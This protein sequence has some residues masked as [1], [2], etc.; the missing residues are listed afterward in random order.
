MGLLLWPLHGIP[1]R[2]PHA[3]S[4]NKQKKREEICVFSLLSRF[5]ISQSPAQYSGP[6]DV[7]DEYVYEDVWLLF[8]DDK[9][10]DIHRLVNSI[11]FINNT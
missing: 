6:E 10:T 8:G 5:I 11:V 3:E 7:L 2:T 1:V 4:I 9:E